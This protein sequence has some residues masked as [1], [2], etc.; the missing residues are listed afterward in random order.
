MAD[1]VDIANDRMLDEMDRRL[2]NHA[3]ARQCPVAEECEDC[4]DPIPF[5]HVQ[6]LA[7]LPCL[8]CVECQGYHERKGGGL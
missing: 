8:R 3:L 7:K 4:G 2:A 5:E 1:A 6:A